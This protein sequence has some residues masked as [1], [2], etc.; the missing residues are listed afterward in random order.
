MQVRRWMAKGKDHVQQ[1]PR[2]RDT[3]TVALVQDVLKT[4]EIP[5]PL[6]V[7]GP[8]GYPDGLED[9]DGETLDGL[10]QEHPAAAPHVDLA[11]T[12]LAFLPREL[13]ASHMQYSPPKS[14]RQILVL[15]N[16]QVRQQDT[17]RR[18][19][20]SLRSHLIKMAP[21]TATVR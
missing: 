1:S 10:K 18:I 16:N 19:S 13:Q 17:Q 2:E 12:R 14:C 8:V 11:T 4:T 7:N 6:N 15:L 9:G 5:D 3:G 21:A 20:T